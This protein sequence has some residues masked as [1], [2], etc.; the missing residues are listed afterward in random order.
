MATEAPDCP[1]CGAGCGT[2][3]NSECGVERGRWHGP[4]DAN[5][6]CPACGTGWVGDDIDVADAWRAFVEYEQS[7]VGR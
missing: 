5:L 6:K 2:P 3:V 4:D 7:Q 1:E